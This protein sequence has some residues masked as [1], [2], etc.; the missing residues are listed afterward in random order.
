MRILVLFFFVAVLGIGFSQMVFLVVPVCAIAFSLKKDAVSEDWLILS[1]ALILELLMIMFFANG[2]G[3]PMA[4]YLATA[5]VLLFLLWKLYQKVN[6]IILFAIGA[7]CSSIVAFGIFLLVVPIALG[8]FLIFGLMHLSWSNVARYLALIPIALACSITLWLQ[9]DLT[10]YF[11]GAA[12]LFI[13]GAIAVS[14]TPK[15]KRLHIPWKTATAIVFMAV[16]GFS[17]NLY[18]P[19]RATQNPRINENLSSRNYHTFVDGMDRKQYGSESYFDRMFHRRGSW[20]HQLG[21]HPNM[22][23]WSYFE[24]EW[25]EAGWGFVPWLLLGILGFVVAIRKRIEIGMPFLAVFLLCSLGIILYMNFADGTKY[26]FQTG[27]AYL[28]VRDRDYFFSSAFVF[29]AIAMGAGVTGLLH[30]VRE[31]L[32]KQSQGV[33]NGVVYGLGSLLLLMPTVALAINYHMDDRSD[34]YLPYA[35]AK[36]LL[37]SCDK[38]AIIFTSGD[39][40]TFPVWA[41]QEAYNYRKDVRVVNLSLLNTDWYV[42]EMKENFGIPITLT[43]EQ[44]LWNPFEV[45]PGVF[46][47]RPDSTF[48][49]RPR[50][51]TTYL[52]PTMN[53]GRLVK[54]QDMMVDE[55]VI[56]N[57]WKC[58]IY[59]SSP[60]YSESPLKLRDHMVSV[61]MVYRIDRDDKMGGIDIDR[62]YDLFMND[63]QFPGLND[64]KLFRDENA[65]GIFVGVGI[66]TGKLFDALMK[67]GDST[68]AIALMNHMIKVYPEYWSTVS[69]LGEY[70]DNQKDSAKA[71]ALWQQTVDTLG[72]FVKSNPRNLIWRQDYGYTMVELARRKNDSAMINRGIALLKEG[73]DGDRNSAFAFRKYAQVLYNERRFSDLQEAAKQFTEYK[74]NLGDPLAQQILGIKNS[75]ELT[76]PDE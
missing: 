37:D 10:V 14:A 42:Y 18:L 22:G 65:T 73:F 29:F 28:E 74:I 56:Q 35:Y 39:N 69:I 66:P 62:S 24:T 48:Y 16:I 52:I 15:E 54:V 1:S 9:W 26:D 44:I 41:L 21:R 63:Y 43:K 71:T 33:V 4:F 67:R 30:I 55:I 38:D 64:S 5:F 32:R 49:D 36:N 27:D 19:V 60:P 3:G 20:A 61:G 25:S 47:N 58:P 6:W 72:A 68:R 46:A 31:N 70:Y 7:V 76:P 50:K 34:N 45:R 2:R 75:P 13:I 23:F 53:D 51:R 11:A 59:F 8:L 12:V 17:V 57:A 40:D